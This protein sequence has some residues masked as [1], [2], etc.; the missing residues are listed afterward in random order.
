MASRTKNATRNIIWGITYKVSTLLLPFIV[1]TVMIYS[2]GSEY[3]GLSSLFTSVLNVLSLAELG[4]GSAMV[5]AMYKPIAEKDTY[6]VCALLNLYKKIYRIIGIVIICAGL[7][8]MPFLRR[9]ISGD[10]PND[11]N[12]YILFIIYLVNTAGS[13][14]LFAYQASVLNAS[15]RN[16]VASKVNMFTGITKNLLQIIVLIL[17]HNYYGYVVLLPLTSLTANIILAFCAW[18]MYPEYVCRGQVETRLV[19][20]IKGKVMALFAVKITN[21]IYNSVDSIVISAFL[22]LVALAKYNNYYYIMN[23]IISIVTVVFTSIISSIGNSIVLESDQKNYHDYMNLSFINA[24]IVGWCTVCLFCL[25]QPFMKLWVGEDLMFGMGIVVCFCIYFYAFQLK[26]VQSAYKDAAGLWKEDMWRSYAANIFNLV[27]NIILV[28][29]IGIYGILLSTILALTLITYPWQTWM[30]HKKLFH[31]S[32]WPYLIKLGIYT[33]VTLIA[34]GVT[35]FICTLITEE[36]ILSFFI[37][38]IICMIVPNITFLIAMFRMKEFKET[39]KIV[40]RV[41]KK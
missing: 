36:N 26:S 10:V 41:L 31:C 11:V 20:E 9:F 23:A 35:Y 39:I 14:L 12:I 5:Y 8:I 18:K 16:D 32:M 4:V 25:Y 7:I 28:K 1:R 15:Q 3:L 2:L 37:K 34:C 21:V 29:T 22:G 13:Y 38:I 27:M 33:I 24:W 19:K 40:R 17:W 6:T 30:I